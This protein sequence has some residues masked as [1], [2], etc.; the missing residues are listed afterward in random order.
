MD[1]ILLVDAVSGV[2]LVRGGPVGTEAVN[3]QNHP[4]DQPNVPTHTPWCGDQHCKDQ[5][6]QSDLWTLQLHALFLS[7]Y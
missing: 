4:T 5:T 7:E 2:V 1:P 3:F 6:V